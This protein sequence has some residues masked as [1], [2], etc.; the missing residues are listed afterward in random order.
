[1]P[2]DPFAHLGRVQTLEGVACANYGDLRFMTALS[3][4][5]K[6]YSPRHALSTMRI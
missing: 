3:Y 2:A 6:I 1:M 4:H 5:S